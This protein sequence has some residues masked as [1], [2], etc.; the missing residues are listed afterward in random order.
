M[1]DRILLLQVLIRNKWNR[2]LRDRVHECGR[3]N[4]RVTICVTF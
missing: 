4:L 3:S 1:L 2:I